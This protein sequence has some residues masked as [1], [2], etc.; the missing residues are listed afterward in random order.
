MH[1]CN[2][3]SGGCRTVAV[4]D[5][6]GGGLGAYPVCAVPGDALVRV[7]GTD[8]QP[9]LY[10]A[11]HALGGVLDDLIGA[12]KSQLKDLAMQTLEDPDVRQAIDDLLV[13]ES[14]RVT[15]AVA[16]GVLPLTILTVATALGV[17][18]LAYREARR[19][20]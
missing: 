11:R 10:R 20:R 15:A 1:G 6:K 18:W 17:G 16:K 12:G 2:G 3:C 4:Y 5:D 7:G 9:T 8:A 14:P 13:A 19:S